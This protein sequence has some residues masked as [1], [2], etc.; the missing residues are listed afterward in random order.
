MQDKVPINLFFLFLLVEIVN[1]EEMRFDI[2]V[3]RNLLFRFV[4]VTR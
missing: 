1:F 4:D 3:I 2:L